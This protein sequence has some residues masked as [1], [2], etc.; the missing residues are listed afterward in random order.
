MMLLNHL[1]SLWLVI[2]KVWHRSRSHTMTLGG[3]CLYGSRLWRWL[4][5]VLLTIL[6]LVI[7]LVVYGH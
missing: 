7:I 5:F 2:N 4:L 3:H 6:V 1:V